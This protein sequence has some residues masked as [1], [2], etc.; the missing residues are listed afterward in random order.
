MDP[1]LSI[2]IVWPLAAEEAIAA[3][4]ERIEPAH[5]LNAALKFAELEEAHFHQMAQDG[6]MARQLVQ[7]RGAVCAM[8]RERGVSVPE[9]STALRRGL[10]EKLGRGGGGQPRG[11]VIHRSDAAREVCGAAEAAAQRAGEQRWG[12][13]HLAA[14]LLEAPGTRIASVLAE[15][16]VAAGASGADT[17]LLDQYGRD[18]TAQA[19]EG[20]LGVSSDAKPD[21][22]CK[23]LLEELL[24]PNT[25]NVALVQA[26]ERTPDEVVE[27][28]AVLFAGD[29]PP[30][31][32]AGK[33]IIEVSLARLGED[34]TDAE[35]LEERVAGLLREASEAG[36]V[37]LW[38]STLHC[39]FALNCPGL[40]KQVE[41][42][43][44]RSENP[45][46][47]SMSKA[48]Y[49]EHIKSNPAWKKLLRSVWLHDMKD[50]LQ[51]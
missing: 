47:V 8:L 48:G 26:G 16:G 29:S 43:L 6:A 33:R 35:T 1:G 11:R 40:L 41:R 23:V 21:A 27:R 14:E 28:L 42:H 24:G 44:S 36:S 5:L 49:N 12:A 9:G 45:A 39:Y 31:G 15:C 51:L 37:M 3:G 10:R 20:A 32:A 4:F 2:Q 13:A 18:V 50:S 34:V 38:F 25:R 7:E 22:A 19:R 46:I 17:P 30:K